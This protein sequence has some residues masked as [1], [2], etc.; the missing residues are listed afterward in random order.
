MDR[1]EAQAVIAREIEGLT[2]RLG[3]THWEVR[4]STEPFRRGPGD[5]P[6]GE[7]T[8]DADYEHAYVQLDADAIDT[9]EKLLRVFRHELFHVLLAPFRVYREAVTTHVRAGTAADR[10]EQRVWRH[11]EEQ[12]VVNLERMYRGLAGPAPA[13]AVPGPAPA[14][15]PGPPRGAGRRR[16][17]REG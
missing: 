15:D 5:S 9:E 8:P 1:G 2:R 10:T 7:C 17:R 4:V 13:A 12:A 11:A 6:L 16:S 14:P 3:L